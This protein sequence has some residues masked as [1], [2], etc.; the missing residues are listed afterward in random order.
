MHWFCL[1]YVKSKEDADE[2][3]ND[4]FL[5]IWDKKD[6][7]NF[8]DSLKSYL[9]TTVRNKSINFLKKKK[10]E[11]SFDDNMHNVSNIESSPSQIIEGKEVAKFINIFIEQ[12]PTKCKQVFILSRKEQMSNKEI[13]Q[14]LEISPKTVENQIGIAIKIIKHK[15]DSI[16]KPKGGNFSLQALIALSLI[17]FY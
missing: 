5:S 3:V 9:Y 17:S 7:L 8:D 13:A 1:Q 16:N 12:L 15:L 2:I 10:I 4:A 6:T 14:L 11:F